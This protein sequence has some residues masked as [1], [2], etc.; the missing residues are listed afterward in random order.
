MNWRTLSWA[1]LVSILFLATS[2]ALLY[3]APKKPKGKETPVEVTLPSAPD[4]IRDDAMGLSYPAKLLTGGAVRL[5]VDLDRAIT[6]DFLT[7]ASGS[8]NFS[9]VLTSSSVFMLVVPVE[10][11]DIDCTTVPGDLAC[12]NLENGFRAI[13]PFGTTGRARIVANFTFDGDQYRFRM[14]PS[15]ISIE[16]PDTGSAP[17][18]RL[19]SSRVY[20]AGGWLQLH[21]VEAL[22]DWI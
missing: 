21:K 20:G 10:S 12:P 17:G 22:G 16:E 3:P 15:L 13:S 6:F 8:N 7:P 18:N 4:K 9:G 5:D 19:R 1:S 11:D 14:G 2:A